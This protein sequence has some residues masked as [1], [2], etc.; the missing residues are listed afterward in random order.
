VPLADG[1]LREVLIQFASY[2]GVPVDVPN[3][4]ALQRLF[5]AE[6]SGKE[7]VCLIKA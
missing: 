1:E 2:C 7:P 5:I 3:N 6:E 4:I